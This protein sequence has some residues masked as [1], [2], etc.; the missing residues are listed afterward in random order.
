VFLV[1]LVVILGLTTWAGAVVGVVGALVAS[2]LENFYFV[3]PLHT[4]EVARPDDLVA[5][6][7]FLIFA[8]ASSVVV[9]RFARRSLEADRA[10]AEAAILAEA[11]V[12]FATS[13][14]DLLPLLDSL[15]NVFAASSVAILGL[16]EGEWRAD[17]VSGE[18]FTS[19]EGAHSFDIDEEHRLV[20]SGT[21]LND[22]DNHLVG[23]FAGRMAAGLRAQ[24]I[25]RDS[26]QLE[27]LAEAESLR[28]A[29][30]RT[31]SKELLGPLEKVQ[32]NISLLSGSHE[33]RSL[34]ERKAVLSGIES[35]VR[36][37]TRLVVN[38]LDAG[39]LEAGEVVAHPEVMRLD[40]VL[41]SA[42]ASVDAKG[43]T[44]ERDVPSSLPELTSD[45]VLVQRVIANVVSNACRF[46]PVDQ[47]VLLKAGVVGDRIELLVIDRGPGM[48][49]AQRDVVLAPFDRLSGDQLNAG[50]NLTVASGFMQALGGRLHFE[51]TPS[52][53][54]TVAIE[55]SLDGT[56]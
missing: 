44:I 1:Y 12:N 41:N 30:F 53:G 24:I 32:A 45:P 4:L 47:P 11:T 39:R 23:A 21:A 51:D 18:P 54:L 42:L 29:L 48:S 17:L 43:R 15:R 9:T 16:R 25:A 20:V 50:L 34:D 31:A 35:Q 3:K 36:Q 38:I 28:L 2:G 22:Q 46:G 26:A 19:V 8:V 49:A 5:L 37:L 52:G 56:T 33:L 40:V 10:R 13:H 55:L 7:A 14:E 27:E 6:V